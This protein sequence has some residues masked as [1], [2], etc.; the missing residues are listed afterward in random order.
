MLNPWMT[1][2]ILKEQDNRDKLKMKFIQHKI[3]NSQDHKNYKKSRNKC[4]RMVRRAK[5][6]YLQNECGECGGDSTKMWK[7]INKA[8]NK[9]AKPNIIPDFIKIKNADGDNEKVKCKTSIANEINNQF[10]LMGKT[11]RVE[12]TDENPKDY[13][14]SPKQNS[15]LLKSSYSQKLKDLSENW[16]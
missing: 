1:N 11:C 2:A 15:I 8:T 3:P 16:M 4:N 14:G 13:L 6:N 7:V 9:K 5:I 12:S 10:R